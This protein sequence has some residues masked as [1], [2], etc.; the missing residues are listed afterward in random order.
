MCF[1]YV[2]NHLHALTWKYSIRT[3]QMKL[4]KAASIYVGIQTLVNDS[5]DLDPGLDL[6]YFSSETR[7]LVAWWNRG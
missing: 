5:L 2:I 4:K 1:D 6:E 7:I 3:G